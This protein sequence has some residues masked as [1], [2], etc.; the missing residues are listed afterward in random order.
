MITKKE[1]LENLEQVKKYI[2]EAEKEKKEENK[3]R[4]TIRN[5]WNGSIIFESSKTT[6]REA[7]EEAIQKGAS[8]TYADLT[9][10]S[11]TGAD[12]T[13]A[14]LTNADLTGA[15]LTNASLT[16]ADLTNASLTYADL[17][18][19]SL[20]GAD[21]TDADL[22]GADLTN[23]D[24]TGA[25]LKACIFYMGNSNR[26]FEALCRAIKTIKHPDGSFDQLTK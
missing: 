9:N 13:N 6:Y 20:T 8:L 1:V 4:F 17:T 12:L 19:A 15:D 10:A 5:R 11:L 22:T 18:R 24:L 7:V 3:I 21:L 23:A 25:N 16:G 26:N 14:S 2:E